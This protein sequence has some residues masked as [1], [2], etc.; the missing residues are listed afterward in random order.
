MEQIYDIISSPLIAAIWKI[1]SLVWTGIGALF[2]W[3]MSRFLNHFSKML[4]HISDMQRELAIQGQAIRSVT[5][6]VEEHDDRLWEIATG[7]KRRKP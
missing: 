2:L 7:R 3:M 5:E 4:K 6:R 1:V